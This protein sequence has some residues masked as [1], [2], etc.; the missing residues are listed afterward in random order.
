[1]VKDKVKA[2]FDAINILLI[3]ANDNLKELVLKLESAKETLTVDNKFDPI[4]M[5]D[6]LE[7]LSVTGGTIG[8]ALKFDKVLETIKS[9][10]S[11]MSHP[12]IEKLTDCILANLEN[13]NKTIMVELT[14]SFNPH[15][16][17]VFCVIIACT[18]SF[19]LFNICDDESFLS[20][21]IENFLLSLDTLIKQL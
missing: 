14:A 17:G 3:G 21:I 5:I 4:K 10:T 18:Y 1:M 6:F 12:T 11:F 13:A 20:K 16:L 8:F 7:K 15:V 2:H 19:L 9:C